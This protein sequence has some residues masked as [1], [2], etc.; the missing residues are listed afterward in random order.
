MWLL[1][2]ENVIDDNLKQHFKEVPEKAKLLKDQKRWRSVRLTKNLQRSK[3]KRD[4]EKKLH[5]ICS[6]VQAEESMNSVNTCINQ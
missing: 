4:K 3:S 2:K 5:S 6:D 1:L